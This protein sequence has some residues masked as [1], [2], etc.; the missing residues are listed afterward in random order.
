MDGQQQLQDAWGDW[1]ST[2]PWQAWCT[3]TFKEEWPDGTVFTPTQAS[4]TRA[5]GRF[6]RWL[7]KDS[8]GLGWFCAHEVG[9][10]GRLHLH[11]LL[12]G[13]E[14]YTSRRALW[15]WWHDRYGRAQILPYDRERG[16]AYYLTKYV[17]KELAHYEIEAPSGSG[18]RTHHPQGRVLLLRGGH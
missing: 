4:A 15:K 8:P 11:A 9:S 3:L 7:R 13:M 10:L 16:A 17:A 1:L 6:T 2:F 12:G 14:P 5:F 18:S